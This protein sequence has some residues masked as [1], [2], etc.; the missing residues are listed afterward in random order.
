MRYDFNFLNVNGIAQYMQVLTRKPP[1]HEYNTD[2]Q[3]IVAVIT[4]GLPTRPSGDP[5]FDPDQI[6]DEM[7]NLMNQCWNRDPG[8]RPT[9]KEITQWLNVEGPMR[10]RNDEIHDH[11][12][13]KRHRFQHAMV[14]NGDVLPDLDKV[15]RILDEVRFLRHSTWCLIADKQSPVLSSKGSIAGA[16]Q[17]LLSKGRRRRCQ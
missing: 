1:L 13:Q 12:V 7:W 11:V 3:T 2:A 5:R 8:D 10:G 6:N 9:C 4:G 17:L 15:E 16:L 14:M